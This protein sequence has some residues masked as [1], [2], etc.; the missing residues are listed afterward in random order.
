MWNF[1][2]NLIDLIKMF[3]A[4][5]N[6]V[7][8]ILVV[9]GLWLYF[10]HIHTPLMGFTRDICEGAGERALSAAIVVIGLMTLVFLTVH[11]W[12]VAFLTKKGRRRLFL[13]IRYFLLIKAVMTQKRR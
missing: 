12:I 8:L 5:S 10:F 2:R 6:I 13:S 7:V 1:V 3:P 11:T 4:V 9:G